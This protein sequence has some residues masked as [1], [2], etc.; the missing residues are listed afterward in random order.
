[1]KIFKLILIF[2]YLITPAKSNSIY[3]LIKI[4][5]LEIYELKTP[6]K[7]KYFYAEKPFRLGVQK[8]IECTNSDKKTYDDK[9]LI[10]FKNL[11]RYS[12]EFLRKINLKYIVMCE[13]LSIS[14][15][16]TA[17]IPDHLMK[18]LILDLKFSEKYFERVIHHELFHII[19]DGFKDLF[20]ED[21]WKKFNEPSFKYAD[22]STCSKKLGLD[23]YKNT[24]GFFTEYSM[25]IPSEDMAEVYSHLITKRYKRS[26]D[27]ILNKKIEFIKNRLK[28]IDNT[29]VF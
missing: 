25:T 17:G 12:K 11:N 13:N 18:T 9:Y 2:F 27:E 4:P 21:A 19:N 28:K 23:T 22:C 15:I 8:N 10:I 14:G 29:F 6:N 5:N 20:N 24:K 3:N 1:M 16:N 26:D 7:L